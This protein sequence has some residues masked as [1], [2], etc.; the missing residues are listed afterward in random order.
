MAH[1]T[2]IASLGL[3]RRLEPLCLL[4]KESAQAQAK[5][6]SL[7]QFSH[8]EQTPEA[9]TSCRVLRG[10]KPQV[11]MDSDSLEKNIKMINSVCT[12]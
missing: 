6:W 3:P 11:L 12:L 10:R 4:P 2:K 7:L 8:R 9:V 1:P 5:P